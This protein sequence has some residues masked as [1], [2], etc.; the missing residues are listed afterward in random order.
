MKQPR[1]NSVCQ[2][3]DRK[4]E[5]VKRKI[6]QRKDGPEQSVENGIGKTALAHTKQLTQSSAGKRAVRHGSPGRIMLVTT[7]IQHLSP[8]TPH[9]S[10]KIIR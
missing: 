2:R 7:K 4:S 8:P 3:G 1:E 6:C 10:K 9:L 5:T